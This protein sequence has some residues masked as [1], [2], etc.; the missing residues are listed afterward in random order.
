MNLVEKLNLRLNRMTHRVS[1]LPVLVLMPHGGCN[2]RCLM[3]DIWRANKNAQEID[4]DQL[5]H[6]VAGLKSLGVR[7][8]VLSGGEALMHS[9]LAGLCKTLATLDAKLTLL[10][11]G[12]LL[13]RNIA[14]IDEWFEEVILSLDGSEAVHNRI[15]NV[16]GAFEKLA[17]GVH[18]LRSHSPDVQIGARCVVQRENYKDFAGVIQ[19]AKALRLDWVS[20]LAADV[21]SEAF[22][23]AGGWG[24]GRIAEVS[25]SAEQCDEF[26]NILRQSFIDRQADFASGFIVEAPDKLSRIVAYYRAI[27]GAAPY[28]RQRCNAPWVSAVIEP[29]GRV[30]PCYF[31]EPY[32]RLD[33]ADIRDV[34]NSPAAQAFRRGLD[35]N[36]NPT[37]QRCVC[38]LNI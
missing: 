8:I 25:L 34:I 18:A 33:G 3:C 29:D 35:V 22:N 36:A 37:C 11:T 14:V 31:H 32:G 16:P 28:P 10:S 26:E 30:R 12:L 23:R 9:N 6:H 20:F 1:R 27:A 19:T 15:R 2:C 5:E 38:T 17:K 13:E 21:S 4:A 24:A 7:W